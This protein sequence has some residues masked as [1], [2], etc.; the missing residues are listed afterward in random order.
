MALTIKIE[1]LSKLIDLFSRPGIYSIND[2]ESFLQLPFEKYKDHLQYLIDNGLPIHLT[3]KVDT[4]VSPGLKKLQEIN[5][6]S[7]LSQFFSESNLSLECHI[8]V[9]STNEL[10][11]DALRQKKEPILIAADYQISGKGQSNKKWLS[12]PCEGIL[13]SIG[14]SIKEEIGELRMV[15]L[16]IGSIIH[17][18]LEIKGYKGLKVKW[19]NDLYFNDRKLCGILVE[20]V[21]N[22]KGVIDLIVGVGI[23]I[24]STRLLKM[25]SNMLPVGL[26]EISNIDIDKDTLIAELSHQI[27]GSLKTQNYKHNNEIVNYINEFNYLSGRH[28]RVHDAHNAEIGVINNVMPDGGIQFMANGVTKGI[29]TGSIELI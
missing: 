28:V 16:M 10:A 21:I 24:S 20:S 1:I 15:S 23:N 29:Y 22:H 3:T 9:N 25:N 14:A 2:I 13:F 11:R 6:Q 8:C 17:R 7:R 12:S 18:H 27:L 4:Y 19:P 5:I 26:K